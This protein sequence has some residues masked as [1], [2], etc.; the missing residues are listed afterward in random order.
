MSFT[1]IDIDIGRFDAET[2]A[3]NR[4]SKLMRNICE[5]QTDVV[6]PPPMRFVD[7]II[8]TEDQN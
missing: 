6:V 4:V 8:E 7:S 2:L 1:V 3:Q 5:P